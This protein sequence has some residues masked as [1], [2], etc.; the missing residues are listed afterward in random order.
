MFI[1]SIMR[2]FF[3]EVD[4][5]GIVL[6]ANMSLCSVALAGSCGRTL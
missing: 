1:K 3:H 5:V 2:S 6:A 4:L